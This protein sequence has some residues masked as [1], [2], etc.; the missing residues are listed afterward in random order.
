MSRA[1][2]YL[3]I[4]WF[5]ISP[6][7]AAAPLRLGQT[8]ERNE[9][10]KVIKEF[11]ALDAEFGST[12]TTK[13]FPVSISG[14]NTELLTIEESCGSGGC[15]YFIVERFAEGKKVKFKLLA[16]FFGHINV[17]ESSSKGYRH[18]KIKNNTGGK[19]SEY[20]LKYNGEYFARK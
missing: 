2:L 9:L 19:T 12:I 18:I 1:I 17:L 11:A 16:D 8:Y 14:R 13:P 6:A 10:Q 5:A 4:V 20:T 15:Q 7:K 3:L